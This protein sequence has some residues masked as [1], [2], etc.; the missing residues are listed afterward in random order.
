VRL[1]AGPTA[2]VTL[3]TRHPPPG[4]ADCRPGQGMSSGIRQ[5]QPASL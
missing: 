4:A 2:A 1:I 5:Q 3:A